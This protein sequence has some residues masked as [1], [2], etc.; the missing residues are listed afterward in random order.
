MLHLRASTLADTNAIAAALAELSRTGDLIVLAG[1][2][3][4]GKTAF[5]KAFGASLGVTEPI[6][7]PTY[8]LVHSYD[9]GRITLHHA[10]VYR[11]ST[12]HE[13]SDL[14]LNELL[15]SD[16]IVLVEWGDVVGRALGDHLLVRLE[17]GDTDESE[18]MRSITLDATGRAWAVRWDRIEA[19]VTRFAC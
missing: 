4:A 13:V 6:T 5:A 7:S 14:A 1:E 8:T 2:M 16:G 3:G 10:D 11:L 9:A 12:H 19:A 18:E 15:E 17:H